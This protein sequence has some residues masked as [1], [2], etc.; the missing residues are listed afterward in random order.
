VAVA[1]FGLQI[2]VIALRLIRFTR[3]TQGMI[4]APPLPG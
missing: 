2:D 1:R 3:K 4:P